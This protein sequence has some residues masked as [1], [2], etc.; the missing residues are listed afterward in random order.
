MVLGLYGIQVLP[1]IPEILRAKSEDFGFPAMISE[2]LLRS[3]QQNF[4]T[5][6]FD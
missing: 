5:C 2:I 1:L 4:A 3:L 6:G